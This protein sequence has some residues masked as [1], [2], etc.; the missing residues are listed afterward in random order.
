VKLLICL[1]VALA[2]GARPAAADA[3]Y[4]PQA[5]DVVEAAYRAAGLD[6][7]PVRGLLRRARLGGLIPWLTVRT[8]KSTSWQDPIAPGTQQPA[9]DVDHGTTF[10]VRA[11]WRLDRLV[12]DGREMQMAALDAARR[13]E[14]RRLAARVVRTYFAWKRAVTGTERIVAPDGFVTDEGTGAR[15]R[16]ARAE[17]AAAELDALT[18]GWFSTQ[19]STTPNRPK[20]GH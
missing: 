5:S 18:E 11:T 10:E 14:R 3:L 19:L 13:R 12:F 20:S 4:A 7:D 9:S 1:Y 2:A 16:A 17:E 15:T 8:G 6:R